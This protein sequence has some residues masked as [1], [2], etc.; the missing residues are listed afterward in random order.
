MRTVLLSAFA[1]LSVF[2]TVLFS[3]CKSEPCDD[4]ICAYG[5]VCDDGSCKC[6]AGYEGTH[7]ETLTYTKYEGIWY[8]TEDGTF[9]GPTQ[10]SISIVKGGKMNEIRIKN[11][12]NKFTNDVIAEVTGTKLTIRKQS[13]LA[14][15]YVE[16]Y[17]EL[18]PTSYYSQH[19]SIKLYYNVIDDFGK[20]NDFGTADGN[21][22]EY[23]K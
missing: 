21:P 2:S 8:V 7:C 16:G 1:T 17:G 9:S 10:Y 20:K 3:S 19:A 4:I 6:Q 22:S 18:T 11:F 14:G 5:G 23:V 12:Y 15:W 13:P